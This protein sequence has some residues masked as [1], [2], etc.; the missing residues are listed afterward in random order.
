MEDKRVRVVVGGQ[1]QG[2]FFRDTTRDLAT[3]LDLTGWIRNRSDGRVEA[4]FQGPS[5]AVDRAVTFCQSGPHHARVTD[6]AVERVDLVS[7]E[8]GFQVC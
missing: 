5:A 4:E 7:N 6:I 3:R 8:R 2:V 1:V